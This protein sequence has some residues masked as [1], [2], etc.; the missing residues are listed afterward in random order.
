M[1]IQNQI[2]IPSTVIICTQDNPTFDLRRSITISWKGVE[3]RSTHLR[4]Y[5][6]DGERYYADFDAKYKT[7]VSGKTVL[8]LL[9]SLSGEWSCYEWDE[10]ERRA[11]SSFKLTSEQLVSIIKMMNIKR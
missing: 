10:A 5:I 1:E 2:Q 4:I 3:Y 7:Y 8:K 9:K 11:V 6:F